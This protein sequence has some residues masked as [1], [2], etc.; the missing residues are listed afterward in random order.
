MVTKQ[1]MAQA[2]ITTNI[3]TNKISSSFWNVLWRIINDN[4]TDPKR[5]NIKWLWSAYP[6][7]VLENANAAETIKEQYPIVVIEPVLPA[8]EP[9]TVDQNMRNYTV[10]FTITVF[11]DRSDHLDSINDEIDKIIYDNMSALF[12]TG[13]TYPTLVNSDYDYFMRSG[14]KVHY[15]TLNYEAEVTKYS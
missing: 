7:E 10:S 12:K 5:R 3:D 15:K 1:K 14:V 8:H 6:D 11:A 9:I 13:I 4:I 2:A